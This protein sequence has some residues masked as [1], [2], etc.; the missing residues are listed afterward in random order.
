MEYKQIKFIS[1]LSKKLKNK[2]KDDLKGLVNI[3]LP[4][5]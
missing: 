4:N 2:K 3:N 1:G 5:L